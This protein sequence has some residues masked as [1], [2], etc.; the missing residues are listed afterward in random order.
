MKIT[1]TTIKAGNILVFN[2]E[3]WIVSKQPEHTKP[4]KGPAYMQVEMKNLKTGNKLNQR[5]NS[6]DYIEKAQLE[7]RDFQF[8]YMEGD[9]MVLMDL[10]NFEQIHVGKDIL[11]ADKLPFLE[12]NMQIT[13]E[14]YEDTPLNVTLPSTVTLEVVETDP[15]IKGATATASYKPAILSNGI[16]VLV[17]PYLVTGEFIVVK[18]E[19][20][21]F[22][23]RAK[24]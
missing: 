2:D 15:I 8:L 3:L 23:E 7:Q 5:F 13:V 9:N 20:A 1:A 6:S 16:R 22:V 18:T 14:F 12:D 21:S 11:E 10:E 19:D 24:K 4:G 17:P